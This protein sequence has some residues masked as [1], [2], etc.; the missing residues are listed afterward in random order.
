MGAFFFFF[1][2]FNLLVLRAE[3]GKITRNRNLCYDNQIK[4]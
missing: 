3:K 1:F 2:H 4:F